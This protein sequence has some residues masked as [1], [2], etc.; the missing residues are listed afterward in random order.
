MSN[1]TINN[2]TNNNFNTVDAAT[3]AMLQE[4]V[5]THQVTPE[6][7]KEVAKQQKN[8]FVYS[9]A[10]NHIAVCNACGQ[11]FNVADIPAAFADACKK[12]GICPE[13]AEAFARTEALK[14]NLRN[15]N[16]S[17][18]GSKV[19]VHGGKKVG[20]RLQAMFND[21]IKSENF[22]EEIFAKFLD[23]TYSNQTLKFSSYPL[24]T[25][26]TDIPE[27]EIK[28]NREYYKRFYSKPYEIFSKKIRL[29]SQIVDKQFEACEAE[30]KK[31]GLV[32]ADIQY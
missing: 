26:V 29:C 17:A 27:A 6:M 12:Q 28:E 3:L 5:A 13:C 23:F 25:D 14:A 32:N 30:F 2:N 1:N 16:I 15:K 24:L 31:L 11:E 19:V 8:N 10:A 22:S 7:L 18:R 21:A 9:D 4:F 20:Q